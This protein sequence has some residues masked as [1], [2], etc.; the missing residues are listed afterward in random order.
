MF[1]GNYFS[2]S[3]RGNVPA[4]I[5]HCPSVQRLFVRAVLGKT[6]VGGAGNEAIQA[7]F[8]AG[9]NPALPSLLRVK[10]QG[11]IIASFSL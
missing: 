4:P 10:I 3:G 9:K 7:K 8:V 11:F 6:G 1:L 5:L 2:W